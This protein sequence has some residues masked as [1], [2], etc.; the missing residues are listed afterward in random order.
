MIYVPEFQAGKFLKYLPI[1][2]ASHR[3]IHGLNAIFS[4]RHVTEFTNVL[5][6]TTNRSN[7]L[8][9]PNINRLESELFFAITVFER[10]LHCRRTKT[11]VQLGRTPLRG[12]RNTTIS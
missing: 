5:P 11:R 6:T 4:R 8:R 7:T 12:Q 3:S 9:R 10:N 1:P 2:I